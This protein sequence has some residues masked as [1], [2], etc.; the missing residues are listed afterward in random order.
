MRKQDP[1]EH[2]IEYFSSAPLPTA[3]TVL[4]I[5]RSIVKRRDATI[6]ETGRPPKRSR[7]TPAPGLPIHTPEDPQ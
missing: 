4:A 5:C 6:H 3:I 1:A 2:V 7:H